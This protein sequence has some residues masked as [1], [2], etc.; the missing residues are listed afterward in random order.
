LS[1]IKHLLEKS[2]DKVTSAAHARHALANEGPTRT[3]QRINH[4]VLFDQ[5]R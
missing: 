3:G 5:V 2:S 1:L 4:L